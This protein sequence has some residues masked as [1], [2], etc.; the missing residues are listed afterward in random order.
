M[1]NSAYNIFLAIVEDNIGY[2]N[3]YSPKGYDELRKMQ[4][5]AIHYHKWNILELLINYHSFLNKQ[6]LLNQQEVIIV[7]NV[8]DAKI[9]SKGEI[10]KQLDARV[11][12]TGKKSDQLEKILILLDNGACPENINKYTLSMLSQCGD[13]QV[14][15]LFIK[16]GLNI[17]R[18]IDGISL[19]QD[20]IRWSDKRS[21]AA[22]IAKILIQ[23]GADVNY[24]NAKGESY[25]FHTGNIQLIELL[26]EKGL[27]VNEKSKEGKYPIEKVTNT[28]LIK[29]FLSHDENLKKCL[30]LSNLGVLRDNE[31]IQF[32]AAQKADF[33]ELNNAG[34]TPLT[35]ALMLHLPVNTIEILLTS[36]ADVNLKNNETGFAALH[37]FFI[38]TYNSTK[39]VDYL[40]EVIDLLI[41][42]GA[43]PVKNNIH[44]T[45]LMYLP[46]DFNPLIA[47][48]NIIKYGQFEADFYKVDKELYTNL[49]LQLR[50]NKSGNLSKFPGISSNNKKHIDK[51][52]SAFWNKLCKDKVGKKRKKLSN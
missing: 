8:M 52:N 6:Q 28:E 23:A 21:E 44:R 13:P 49:L 25:L 1:D 15:E 11:Y 31:L 46:I 30:K 24:R 34:N 32:A 29:L 5:C 2:V 22:A 37:I 45:P 3:Q 42:Y 41:K 10:Q 19:L 36:G 4:T 35:Q 14:V 38:H 43:Q 7:N 27:K 20:A 9:L 47:D 50:E 18:S 26:I 17:N 48:N 16:Y 33:N 51:I 40:N 39:K 12:F